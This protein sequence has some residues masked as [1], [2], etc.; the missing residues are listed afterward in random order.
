MGPN[1][2]KNGSLRL[3][4][5]DSDAATRTRV[6]RWV[7]AKGVRVVGEAEDSKAGLRLAR[8]LQPDVVLMELPAQATSVMEFVRQIRSEF[9]STGIILSA[10][11]ASPDLILSSMRAGAQEF[12]ARPIDEAEL[13]KA[14]DHIK[15]LS[16][17]GGHSG[18]R[19][20]R[21]IAVATPKGGT[22][23]TSFTA[24]L[25]LALNSR[26]HSKIALVDMSFTFG[27][28]GVMFDAAPRYSLVDALVDGA[29][30][31]SKLRSIMVSHESGL[32]ILNVASSPEVAEE[33]TRQQ[34]VELMGMLTTTFDFVIV[35]VGRQLDDRT[36]E[37]LELADSI[38]LICELDIP[39]VRNTVCFT[40]LMEKLKIERDKT[41]LV[42]N[43]YHKKSRLS[44]EDVETL[45]GRKVFWS[46]P[47]DF[48]PM[49]VGIDRGVPAVNDAPKSKVAKSYLD[50][51]DRIHE[52]RVTPSDA[53]EAVS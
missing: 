15:R 32:H 38:M 27:D 53:V 34:V 9:P 17:G 3:V 44:F 26:T 43:R 8:G 51:A 49:S 5:I 6:K 52:Q 22:G 20:G 19:R 30:D 13:D 46:I 31:E 28:L 11:E 24:N 36:V 45:V 37:V 48:L 42:I 33:V 18:R 47:N 10:N 35:D 2:N 40:A 29:L 21:V 4:V 1:P 41:H 7:G 14:I 25:G 39:T 23:A 16:N 50:L 12:V